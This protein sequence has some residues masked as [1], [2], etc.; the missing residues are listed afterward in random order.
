MHIQLFFFLSP[1]MNTETRTCSVR[2]HRSG[3]FESIPHWSVPSSSLLQLRC[4]LF[5]SKSISAGEFRSKDILRPGD[6]SA[7]LFSHPS[8]TVSPL[9][10]YLPH[11]S[12]SAL[13]RTPPS[14]SG[15][16]VL[17]PASQLLLLP[18]PSSL[19]ETLV[20][21]RPHLPSALPFN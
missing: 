1:H 20:H 11:S 2:K 4:F 7:I 10:F 18:E 5:L 15:V 6:V 9:A 8:N 14:P 16:R 21:G 17:F 12:H 13:P 3:F 19:R